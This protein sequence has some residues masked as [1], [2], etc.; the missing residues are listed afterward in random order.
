MD[1]M[2]RIVINFNLS[3]IFAWILDGLLIKILGT[4]LAD[5]RMAWYDIPV[6]D[7]DFE[8]RDRAVAQINEVWYFNA[9]SFHSEL[10]FSIIEKEIEVY[11]LLTIPFRLLAVF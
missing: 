10:G 7:D 3:N 1:L 2:K 4:P 11:T 9:F 8:F 5:D 6:F